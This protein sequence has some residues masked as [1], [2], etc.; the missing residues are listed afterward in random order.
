MQTLKYK[1]IYSK[2][3]L[4]KLDKELHFIPLTYDVLFK[5]VFGNNKEILKRFLIEVLELNIKEEDCEIELGMN[6]LFKEQYNNYRARIDIVIVLNKIIRVDLEINREKVED[7]LNRNFTYITKEH[8]MQFKKNINYK[9]FYKYKTIQLNLNTRPFGTEI[10][11]E[12]IFSVRSNNTGKQ[13][14]DNFEIIIKYL[15]YFRNLYYTNN[16]KCKKGQIWLAMLMSKSFSEL[17]RFLE[18]L[19]DP[20]ER[21]HFLMEVINM[22][23]N[24]FFVHQWL[25]EKTARE[26]VESTIEYNQ[27]KKEKEMIKKI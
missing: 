16:G 14:I 8:T 1:T 9:D 23:S 24:E 22:C 20:E 2:D 7:I 6:E 15:E 4:K 3:Y 27:Q 21:D 26:I 12:D 13:V 18:E 19:L 17:G 25:G 5:K 10:N 11:G